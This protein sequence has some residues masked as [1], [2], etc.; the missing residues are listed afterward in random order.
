M[1]WKIPGNEQSGSIL[2]IPAV[3]IILLLSAMKIN[4]FIVTMQ[5]MGN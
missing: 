4:T 1:V 5:R 3:G 2:A